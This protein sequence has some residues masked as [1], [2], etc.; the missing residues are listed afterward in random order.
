METATMPTNPDEILDAR[1]RRRIADAVDREDAPEVLAALI[2]LCP[3]LGADGTLVRCA[4]ELVR[5]RYD[6]LLAES[7]LDD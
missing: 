1:A 3:A 5:A 2:N 7:V 4:L 6:E